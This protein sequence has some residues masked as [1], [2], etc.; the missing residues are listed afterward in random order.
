MSPPCESYLSADQLDEAETFYPLHVRICARVPAGPAAGVHPGRGHLH[1]LRLLLLLL[2]TPGWR[3]PSVS[4]TTGSGRPGLDQ[5]LV[6]RRGRQQR[7]LPAAA[8]RRARHPCL[9]IEPAANVADAARAK[10]I[11]TEV[12]FLGEETGRKIAE[13]TAGPI[14]SSPTTSSRTCRTSSTSPRACAP[15]WP[16]TAGS[17]SRS[18]TCCG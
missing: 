9:G 16:I 18:R 6:R 15:S 11:P 1:R 2:A 17:A 13:A 12:M 4:S 10:G 8:R 5:R 3:T 7:R 14:S